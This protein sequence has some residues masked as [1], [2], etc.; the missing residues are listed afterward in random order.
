MAYSEKL[1]AEGHIG[2]LNPMKIPST[3]ITNPC[4]GT[5]TL[6]VG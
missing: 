5:H 1:M 4:M 3:V 2:G 6:D